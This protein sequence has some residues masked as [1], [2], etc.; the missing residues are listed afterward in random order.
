M[1]ARRNEGRGPGRISRSILTRLSLGGAVLLLVSGAVFFSLH[2]RQARSLYQE[3]AERLV[4]EGEIGLRELSTELLRL[5]RQVVMS[6][7]EHV[8]ELYGDRIRGLPFGLYRRGEAQLKE[9]IL[10][11]SLDLNQ[12]SRRNTDAV[13]GVM[14]ER[15]AEDIAARRRR[16]AELARRAQEDYFRRFRGLSILFVSLST[17]LLAAG[18]GLGL[19][20]WVLRPVRSLQEGTRRIGAGDLDHRIPLHRADELGRLAADF[21]AMT[22]EIQAKTAEVEELNER[23]EHKVA[24][25]TEELRRTVAELEETNRRLE[26]TITELHSTQRQLVR[27]EKMASL[28]RLAGGVAHEFGNLIGGVLGCADLARRAPTVAESRDSL[29]MIYR[30]ARRAQAIVE[31]LLRFARRRPPQRRACRLRPLVEDAFTLL[32]KEISRRE[33]IAENRVEE[34]LELTCDPGQLSQVLVNLATNALHALPPGGRLA[35]GARREEG[36]VTIE[37]ADQGRGIPPADLDRVFEPFFTTKDEGRD[38]VQGTGL[39]LSVTL[40]IVEDHGGTIRVESRPGEGTTFRL[41]FP[42]GEENHG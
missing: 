34:G 26:G 17:T 2:Y 37:V 1:P 19:Y 4:E 40:G 25:R 29:E 36:G 6:T 23:L 39:G 32:G 27:S 42:G 21:N 22:A 30:T 13:L 35:I 20:Y 18:L 9:A 28:G 33:A 15:L 16:H 10:R 12:I 38:G 11:E 5:N 31:S 7:V 41:H 3:N 24:E 14:Q 8:T